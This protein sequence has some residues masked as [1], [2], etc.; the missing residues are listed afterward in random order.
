MITIRY[1]KLDVNDDME[2]G[3]GQ[4]NLT[5]GLYAVGQAIKTRLRLLKGEW[6]EDIEN[7]LPLFKNI[8]GQPG[9]KNNLNIVDSLIKERII[10]LLN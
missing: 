4:Q 9:T 1:R 8:L 6:F 7:G 5:Y 10:G 2:F 3:R